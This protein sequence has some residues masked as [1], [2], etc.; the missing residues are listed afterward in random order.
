MTYTLGQAANATGKSKSTIQAAIKKGRISATKDDIGQWSIDPAELH[1]VFA[2]IVRHVDKSNGTEP[3]RTPDRTAIDHALLLQRVEFLEQLNA[4]LR[5][6]NDT[7]KRLLPPPSP[8]PP[9]AAPQ[10][11]SWFWPW[12]RTS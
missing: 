7:L 6:E 5:G 9:P 11:W 8:Q 12:S 4:Q 1:R 10:P 2:P 3:Q